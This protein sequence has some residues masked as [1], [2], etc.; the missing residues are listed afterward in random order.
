MKGKKSVVERVFDFL[1]GILGVLF[2]IG[3]MAGIMLG[4]YIVL[5]ACMENENYMQDC[6]FWICLGVLIVIPIAAVF[7]IVKCIRDKNK[8]KHHIKE[9]KNN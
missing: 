1:V 2:F 9:R 3:P 6:I 7:I 5:L 4:A 8:M